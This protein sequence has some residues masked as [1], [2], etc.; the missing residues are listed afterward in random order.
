MASALLR[1]FLAYV[2]VETAAVAALIWA[3]GFGWTV[4][5]L[6]AA[7]IAGLVVSTGQVRHQVRRLRSGAGRGA[8]TDSGLV[9]AGTLL[10]AAPGP[11]TTLLGLGLLAPA[12]RPF[13]RPLLVSAATV[14]LGRYTTLVSAAA[15]GR[16][17]YADRSAARRHDYID[18]DVVSAVDVNQPAL[19]AG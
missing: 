10:V 6:L 7:S 4:L 16:R 8:L 18:A 12:T 17:W 9:A 11:V 15:V 1:M 5:G 2:V 14:G 3:A 19:S 13:A